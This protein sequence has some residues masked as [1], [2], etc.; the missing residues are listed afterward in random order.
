[1]AAMESS[2]IRNRFFASRLAG[3]SPGLIAA[4]LF[5]IPY[6]IG[7]AA[8]IA[9][10]AIL[11]LVITALSLWRRAQ[12]EANFVREGCSR[13]LLRGLILRFVRDDLAGPLI[14]GILLATV[15]VRRG[16]GADLVVFT[17]AVL[18]FM[19]PLI[20]WAYYDQWLLDESKCFPANGTEFQLR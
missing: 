15:F 20:A 3:R 1:M 4:I 9:V 18:A 5:A 19:P 16:E 7:V 14:F 12:V 8:P 11:L 13:G 6:G 17:A 10:I 2:A